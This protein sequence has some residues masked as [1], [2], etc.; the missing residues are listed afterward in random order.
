M[1]IVDKEFGEIKI[2]KNKLARSVK[3][4][5]GVDGS[6]RVSIPYYSPEFAV[7]RLVNGNR[8][9]IRK[10]L[11]THNAK[12]SYQDGDLIGKTHA[13][14][15][16][17]FSGEEIKISNEGNQILVQI[18][19]ELAFENPLVQSEIRKTVSKI[20]RKQA[21]AYLPRRIDFLA[22]K[23]GFSF[24][25]LRFSHTGTRW[26][27]CSSSGT[28]SLNIALM[29][30]PH[31]LIDYVIIHELCHTR[32]MNHSFKFWQEVEKYCPDYKKY[33]QEI[34]QFSPSI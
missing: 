7:R 11:A 4:S 33:V 6:L 1:S 9:E 28:I 34:K 17:K 5:V 15:L 10:M 2:R 12:N 30:L 16:R 25:K 8:D 3:L 24:E 14:F 26:G 21:K 22:E 19:Q 32:Q 31:H 29:N 20:L 23:Y 27:S 18:P 13:L